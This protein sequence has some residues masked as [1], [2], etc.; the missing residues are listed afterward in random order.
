MKKYWTVGDFT[1]QANRMTRAT[2]LYGLAIAAA[3]F[4]LRWLEYQYTVRMFATEIY[5]V[6]IA[7]LFTLLG[8]WLGSR[9]TAGRGQDR[10]EKNTK[11]IQ[12]LGISD[13]EYE[14]LVELA[15][16]HSNAEI[17]ERLFIS[18]NTVKSHI[19]QLYAKLEVGRRTQAVQKAR[20]L[21]LVP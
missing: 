6:L 11:A 16:G 10:F 20:A 4:G 13:R 12:S 7:V 1:T 3:A 2:I 18:P 21:R 5:I 14:V 19:K 8:I 17:G 15:G 9:L